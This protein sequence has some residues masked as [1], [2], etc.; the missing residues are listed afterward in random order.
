ME[1]AI[2]TNQQN[3]ALH[4]YFTQVAEKMSDAGYTCRAVLEVAPELQITP[5]FL[6]TL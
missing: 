4:L 5:S 3:A 1:K 2:R 6:K